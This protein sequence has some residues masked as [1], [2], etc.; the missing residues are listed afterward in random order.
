MVRGL[1]IYWANYLNGTSIGRARI[2]GRNADNTFLNG[3]S[4]PTCIIT[5]G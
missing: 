3:L 2:S 4:S 1:W 5:A